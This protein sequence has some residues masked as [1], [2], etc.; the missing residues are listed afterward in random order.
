M[1]ITEAST[2]HATYTQQMHMPHLAIT[3]IMHS[4]CM[5]ACETG[6][7][8]APT[9]YNETKS[10]STSA[11]ASEFGRKPTLASHL[12]HSVKHSVPN[13]HGTQK[14]MVHLNQFLLV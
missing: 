4:T 8:S 10:A 1:T 12:A 2:T 5:H 13:S 3:V 14:V 11:S 7:H 6:T 9:W